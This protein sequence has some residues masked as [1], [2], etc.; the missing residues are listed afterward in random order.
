MVLA[1]GAM[2]LLCHLMTQNPKVTLLR[3]ATWTMSNL[4]RGK[5]QPAFDQISMCLPVLA[6][7]LQAADEEVVIDALWAVSYLS[8][9]S[10]PNNLKIQAVLQ[11]GLG[12]RL[13]ELLMHKSSAV[14]TPALRAVGNIVTGDD[15]QT[16]AMLNA[17]VLHPMLS[18]LGH[19]KRGIRKEA[20][21]AISNITA[22]SGTMPC[23]CVVAAY[24]PCVPLADGRVIFVL[25]GVVLIVC[26]TVARLD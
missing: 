11:A 9:D 20:C 3:N 26:L 5:P 4:C 12:P 7:L 1:S 10:G 13:V 8:D 25:V 16:Q 19:G 23:A 22:G 18:L 14:K 15:H 21:W 6:H 24:V 17:G 2:P